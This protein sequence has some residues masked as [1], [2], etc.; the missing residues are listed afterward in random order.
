MADNNTQETQVN[1]VGN[2]DSNASSEI[3]QNNTNLTAELKD[4]IVSIVSTPTNDNQYI[5]TKV[6]MKKGGRKSH[7]QP[8]KGGKRTSL[9]KSK[10]SKGKSH[11][12]TKGKSRGKK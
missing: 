9:K 11:K 5:E 4:K 1:Q 6:V 7:K 12:K 3:G 8:K 10:K 2:L